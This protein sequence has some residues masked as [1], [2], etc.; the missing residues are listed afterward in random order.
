[1]TQVV[2]LDI[3]RGD[4][5]EHEFQWLHDDVPVPLASWTGVAKIK[6]RLDGVVLAT[7]TVTKTDAVNGWFTVTLTGAQT[8]ALTITTG[9]WD[10]QFTHTD[11]RVVTPVSG[12]VVVSRDVS[13]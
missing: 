6:D 13:P 7:V 8:S 1:M 10:V 2:N 11:T 4:S 9:V 12:A 3:Y 5:Y